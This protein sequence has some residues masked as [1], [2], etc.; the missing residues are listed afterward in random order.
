MV[1]TT[2]PASSLDFLRRVRLARTGILIAIIGVGLGPRTGR[3]DLIYLRKG[4][5]AQLPARIEGNQVILAMPDGEITLARDGIRKIVP[6]F[7]PRTE[8]DSRRQTAG[9]A[10][11][12]ARLATV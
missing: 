6:G 4:G 11:F 2:K 3:A 1:T 12:E 10:S 9:P 8:W 5:E 7:W